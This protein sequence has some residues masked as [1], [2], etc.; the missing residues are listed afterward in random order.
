MRL[1]WLWFDVH[2]TPN[3]ATVETM[4]SGVP[5]DVS[6]LKSPLPNQALLARARW[7]SRRGA[8]ELELLLLPFVQ[9]QLTS[10]DD[11]ALQDYSRLLDCDDWDIFDWL[12]QR[13]KPPPDLAAIVSRIGLSSGES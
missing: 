2:S 10:L 13:S 1:P 8:L 4:T 5:D 11:Q 6:T 7:R 9:T 12:Q 3:A